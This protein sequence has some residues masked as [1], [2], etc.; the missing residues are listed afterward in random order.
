MHSR[1]RTS[2]SP[3]PECAM[4][5]C[6]TSSGSPTVRQMCA[7]NAGCRIDGPPG[8]SL[9]R[10]P[11]LSVDGIELPRLPDI[12]H[13]PAGHDHVHVDGKLGIGGA[14]LLGDPDREPRHPAQVVGLVAALGLVCVRVSR[15][16][17]L[18]DG[19]EA[20]MGERKR[21]GLGDLP[22]QRLVGD[23]SDFG[24]FLADLFSQRVGDG[25]RL[26][27]RNRGRVLFRHGPLVDLSD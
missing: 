18:P 1:L 23:L 2:S 24:Q 22:L 21:P 17:N 20:R 8:L 19:L 5:M 11:A 7:P 10:L 27:V 9:D 4:A 14:H 26:E 25:A 15:R 3:S 12:V 13:Q 16:R 6:A